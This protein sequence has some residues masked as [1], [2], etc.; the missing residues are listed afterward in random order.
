MS[1]YP[2][3]IMGN[4]FARPQGVGAVPVAQLYQAGYG[5]QPP[6]QPQYL[7]VP[8]PPLQLNFPPPPPPRQIGGRR[9]RNHLRVRPPRYNSR[10][11][12]NLALWN[13]NDTTC[14]GCGARAARH[15]CT[16]RR[17]VVCIYCLQIVPPQGTCACGSVV[18]CPLPNLLHGPGQNALCGQ[19]AERNAYGC[20]EHMRIQHRP[21]APAPVAEALIRNLQ[22]GNPVDPRHEALLVPQLRRTRYVLRRNY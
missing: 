22:A 1:G 3:K 20:D 9:R 10:I 8:P 17:V 12:P 21:G 7:P 5:Q 19:H 6:Q 14:P 18:P 15:L 13:P 11:L 2:C 4:P 16:C